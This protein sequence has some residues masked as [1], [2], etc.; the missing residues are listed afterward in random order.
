MGGSI[1]IIYRR[2]NGEVISRIKWTNVM[3]ELLSDLELFAKNDDWMMEFMSGGNAW[4]KEDAPDKHSQ[5]PIAPS[6]YGLIVI[7]FQK[8]SI[9][10][11]NHYT[12]PGHLGSDYFAN[13]DR[14][15]RLSDSSDGGILIE[16][17]EDE[18]TGHSKK[19]YWSKRVHTIR[20]FNEAKTV[21]GVEGWEWQRFIAKLDELKDY[22]QVYF[23]MRPFKVEIFPKWCN[24]YKEEEASMFLCKKRMEELGFVFSPEDEKIW[25]EYFD[26]RR[27]DE[28]VKA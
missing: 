27:E 6:E 23:D 18:V 26:Y 13:A 17:R 8:D 14:F 20:C 19:L 22:C 15:A 25:K 7:D 12:I 9:L 28:K 1:A 5:M 4:L 11:W 21:V 10:S 24:D 2:P 16:S 3:P